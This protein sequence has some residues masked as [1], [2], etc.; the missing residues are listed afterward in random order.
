[1]IRRSTVLNEVTPLLSRGAVPAE[2]VEIVVEIVCEL[3]VGAVD[4]AR[5]FVFEIVV[6]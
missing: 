4:D 1:M 2:A 5:L 6:K 3:V